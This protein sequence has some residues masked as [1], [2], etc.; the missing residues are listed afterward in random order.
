M[1]I[2]ITG[3]LGFIG[4]HL[5]DSL[6]KQNHKITLITKSMSKTTNISH[7]PNRIN[8]EKLDVT[9]FLKLGKFIEKHSKWTQTNGGG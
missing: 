1:K 4:S 9:N 2:I 7:M 5:A 6:L 3:G 8:I